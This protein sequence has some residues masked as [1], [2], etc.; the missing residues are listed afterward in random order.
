V[1]LLTCILFTGGTTA[2]IVWRALDSS[3]PGDDESAP[4]SAHG[5]TCVTTFSELWCRYCKV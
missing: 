3:L 4:D 5:S 2:A 1:F